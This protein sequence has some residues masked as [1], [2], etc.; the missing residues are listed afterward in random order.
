MADKIYSTLKYNVVDYWTV[1]DLLWKLNL[2]SREFQNIEQRISLGLQKSKRI[3]YYC[4][5]TEREREDTRTQEDGEREHES[6]RQAHNGFNGV[7]VIH[8]PDLEWEL[9]EKAIKSLN[10]A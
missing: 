2:L 3:V 7:I 5:T 8:A 10:L 4:S 6:M 9:S 1:G